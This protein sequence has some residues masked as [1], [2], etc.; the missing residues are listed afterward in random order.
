MHL[1]IGLTE[2]GCLM[3]ASFAEQA[4]E[5]LST[6]DGIS[7]VTVEFDH[8]PDWDPTDMT[9]VYRQRLETTRAARR[10]A[11][12]IRFTPTAPPNSSTQPSHTDRGGP[13]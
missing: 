11:L 7:S 5:R 4:R 2:P 1:C 12:R 3:G 9:P 13:G 6:L 8:N 10:Q